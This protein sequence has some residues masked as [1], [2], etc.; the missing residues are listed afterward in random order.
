MAPRMFKMKLAN[1][2]PQFSG[3]S[4]H[5]SQVSTFFPKRIKFEIQIE[6]IVTFL[7]I[8]QLMNFWSL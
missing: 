2:A 8:L 1:F 7:C 6:T 5:D 4:Q 3:Y